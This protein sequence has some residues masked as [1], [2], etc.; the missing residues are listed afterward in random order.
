MGSGRLRKAILIRRI[1]DCSK[2]RIVI[3]YWA[4]AG[5]GLVSHLLGGSF[6]IWQMSTADTASTMRGIIQGRFVWK[7]ASA[8]RYRNLI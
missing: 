5:G 7:V 1:I 3:G 8:K 4:W 2:R 6:V